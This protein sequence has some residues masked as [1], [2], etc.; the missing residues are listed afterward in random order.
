[1]LG[2][3][4]QSLAQAGLLHAW[5]DGEHAQIHII[6]SFFGHDAAQNLLCLIAQHQKLRLGIGNQGADFVCVGASAAD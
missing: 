1:M 4:E 2:T 6:A 5:V 3:R